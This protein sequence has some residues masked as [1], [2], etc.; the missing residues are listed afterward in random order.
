MGC[1]SRWHQNV[2]LDFILFLIRW[3]KKTFDVNI[4][5]VCHHCCG[6]HHTM[7]CVMATPPLLVYIKHVE[8]SDKLCH[9]CDF[10]NIGTITHASL[11]F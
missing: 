7:P 5:F 9:L 4:F 3:I 1:H 6:V 2:D 8:P 11:S 10:V